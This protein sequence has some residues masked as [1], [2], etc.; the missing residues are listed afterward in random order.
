MDPNLPS[1]IHGDVV[2]M[3]QV[4]SNLLTNAVKFSTENT[5]VVL[6]AE[7]Q[8]KIGEEK[9]EI[10][11]SVIDNGVGIK[12]DSQNNIF[13]PFFQVDGSISR[14]HE[15]TGL[16]LSISRRLVE[17]MEGKMWFKSQ[18]NIG[19]TFF[20]NI[21]TA[22]TFDSSPVPPQ[23]RKI[24]IFH[25][26]ERLKNS[27]QKT[28]ETLGFS[29]FSVDSNARPASPLD[30]IFAHSA[31]TKEQ[32]LQLKQLAP[33]IVLLSD[34]AEPPEGISNSSFSRALTSRNLANFLML[35]KRQPREEPKLVKTPTE[36]GAEER[37]AKLRILMAEDNLINQ[38]VIGKLLAKMGVTDLTIVE[39]G[40]K[41]VEA[42]Q[43]KEFDL[44]LM[45]R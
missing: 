4:L 3:R 15:G 27:L 36:V 18:E 19:T 30:I 21:T 12:S 39:N 45:V 20:F 38:K 17:L 40:K 8:R 25:P 37:K 14:R 41:A 43:V 33:D 31:V 44:I 9:A 29:A 10:L 16:G 34:K 2:R 23:D 1:I 24:G 6:C 32:I 35:K 22:A 28:L 11:F 5:E 13:Q 7:M 42:C 26:N